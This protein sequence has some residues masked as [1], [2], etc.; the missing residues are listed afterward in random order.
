VTDGNNCTAT[1][2]ATVV[3]VD[4]MPTTPTIAGTTNGTGTQDQACPEQ[5]LTLTATATGAASYQWYQ[6]NN[7]LN[8]E[9]ASTYQAT[10]V[11]T[12]YVTATNGTCTTPQSAGYVVQNPTPHSPFISA[13][14]PTTFCQGG[15]VQLQS[16]SATGIQWYKNNVAIV[17]A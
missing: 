15:S 10:G 14:G 16:N 1:S 9:T 13:A 6:D 12:Y 3:T 4:T 17:G 2:A 5:P 11:G 8:G 7:T